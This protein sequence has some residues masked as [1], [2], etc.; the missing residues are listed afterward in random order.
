[1]PWWPRPVSEISLSRQS[2]PWL[3]SGLVVCVKHTLWHR[4][5]IGILPANTKYR[6]V[7]KAN[8]RL[9]GIVGQVEGAGKPHLSKVCQRMSGAGQSYLSFMAY[10][11]LL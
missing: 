11:I 4:L 7:G 9:V 8:P 6:L 1:M 10:S 2:L 3:A 5:T